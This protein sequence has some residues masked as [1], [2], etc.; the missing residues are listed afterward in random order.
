MQTLLLA[1]N[2]LRQLEPLSGLPIVRL[3]LGGNAVVDVQP[4]SYLAH[5]NWLDLSRNRVCDIFPLG[6]LSRLV[7]LDMSDDNCPGGMSGLDRLGDAAV[8]VLREPN[9]SP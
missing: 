3:D 1:D 9:R 2:R 5:L 6:A 4:L 7:W 8:V